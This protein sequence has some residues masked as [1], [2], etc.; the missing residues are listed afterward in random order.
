MDNN[1]VTGKFYFDRVGR[2]R[3]SSDDL[4]ITS[5]VAITVDTSTLTIENE[6]GYIH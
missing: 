4:L 2:P 5:P 6:T 3:K 1:A